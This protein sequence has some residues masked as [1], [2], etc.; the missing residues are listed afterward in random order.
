MTMMKTTMRTLLLGLLCAAAPSSQE[1]TA[2]AVMLRLETGDVLWGSIAEHDADGLRFRRID[3]GGL[4][5]LPWSF[6][7]PGESE[8]LRTRFGYVDTQSEEMMIDGDRLVLADGSEMIGRIVDRDDNYVWLKRSEGTIPVPRRSVTG[9]STLVRVPALDIY[10]KE[11]LYQQ[12]ALE[13]QAALLA[14]GNEGARAHDELAQ[15]CEAL[16]D[17]EHAL[18]H[19]KHTSNLDP[20]HEPVRITDALARAETKAALQE[21]VDLMAQIDVWRARK[22]Y[23]LAIEGLKTFRDVYPDSPL[24]DDLNKL[25]DRVAKYQERDVREEIVRVIHSQSVRLAREAARDA[26]RRES[27]GEATFESVLGYLEESMAEDL[28]RNTQK[29]L[30]ELAPGIEEDQ[31]QRMWLE[32]QGGR[33]RQASFGNGTWLLGEGRAL[34]TYEDEG[35]VTDKAPEKGSQAE[36]RKKLEERMS[37]YMRN[38]ELSRKSKSGGGADGDP[39]EYWNDWDYAGRYNWILAYFVEFSGMFK[40]ERVRFANC[41]E[42][43]GTGAREFSFSGSAI[44]GQSANSRLIPCPTCHTIGRVRRIRYR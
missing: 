15:Y 39:G 29:A 35:E 23:D 31:I 30:E 4:V 12:K 14:E 16:F 3:T 44:S 8:Q 42:C 17:F 27:K 21:Q 13:L 1:G 20:G 28:M 5:E 40:I 6:L 24:L 10:T 34:A 43:G 32:R 33:F 11:E 41:R 18:Q 38:Q 7:D 25:Q 22:R 36:A 9:A 37:R 19:Y 2:E 26:G